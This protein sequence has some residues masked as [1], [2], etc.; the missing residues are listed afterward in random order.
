MEPYE[1]EVLMRMF[2]RGL[3][4]NSYKPIEKVRVRID[5]DHVCRLYRVKP[6][7]AKVAR[8]LIQKGYLS[9]HGKSGAVL[10]LTALGVAFVRAKL[11]EKPADSDRRIA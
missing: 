9:D 5:W 2:D 4:G 7:F 3:I 11:I 10:S 6:A 8:H 1:V